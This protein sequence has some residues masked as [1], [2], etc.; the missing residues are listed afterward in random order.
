MKLH[1]SKLCLTMMVVVLR[2]KDNN[3]GPESIKSFILRL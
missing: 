1:L 2:E 3:G